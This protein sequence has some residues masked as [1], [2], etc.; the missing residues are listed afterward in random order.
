MVFDI[1]ESVFEKDKINVFCFLVMDIYR[2]KDGVLSVK[3]E[4]RLVNGL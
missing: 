4:K 3:S 2:V 1:E